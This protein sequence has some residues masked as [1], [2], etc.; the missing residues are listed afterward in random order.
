VPW[1]PT[2]RQQ[3]QA[4]RARQRGN[5]RKVSDKNV[6]AAVDSSEAPPN[7]RAG[8]SKRKRRK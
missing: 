4:E 5:R 2:P 1:A 6:L 7:P 3:A 8:R